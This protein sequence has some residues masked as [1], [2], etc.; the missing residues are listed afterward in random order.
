M[1]YFKFISALVFSLFGLCN[2]A[3]G[4]INTP[5]EVADLVFWVDATDVNANGVQPAN[6]AVITTWADKSGFGNNL[7]RT[8]GTITFEATGFDG[9]NPGLRFPLVADMDGPNPFSGN[10]QN[11]MTV[12]FVNSN[13]T[14]TNNFSLSLNGHNTGANIANGRFSFHTPWINNNVFFD[15]GACCGTTRLR[16]PTPNGLTETTLYTGLNDEVGNSQL[17]RL[18]GTLLVS[19]TTGH[20]A[21]VSGGIHVGDLPSAQRYNGRFAEIIIYKRALNPSEIMDVE[22][23]LLNKWK[24]TVFQTICQANIAAQKTVETWD[25][26]SIGLYSTPGND[27]LYKITV[28]HLGGATLDNN[29]VFLADSLPREIMF[30]NGDIDDVGPETQPVIFTN[31]GSSLSFDILSDLGFSNVSSPPDDMSDCSYAPLVGYDPNVRYIC[32]NPAG[33][34]ASTQPTSSFEVSFRAQIK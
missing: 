13:V 29:S 4:Q 31:N 27:V 8:A 10:F 21:N 7:S 9:V 12:F 3:W 20:N 22:C 33:N 17:L 26:Q 16:N 34:F 14:L 28:T 24:P 32:F 23:Y 5:T 2:L 18:D 6:G 30:F 1:T 11:Q 19:D 25:P 15:A